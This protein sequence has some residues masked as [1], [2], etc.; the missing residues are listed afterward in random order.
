[1]RIAG[2]YSFNGGKEFIQTHFTAEIQE[3]EQIITIIRSEE[4]KTKVSK[5]KTMPGKLLF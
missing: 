1:M 4:H 2:L 5:E 3:I